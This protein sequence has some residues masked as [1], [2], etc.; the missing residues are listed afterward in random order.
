MSIALLGS[1]ELLSCIHFGC[2]AVM[3]IDFLTTSIVMPDRASIEPTYIKYS[4]TVI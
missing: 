2:V 1:P 4:A 3:V